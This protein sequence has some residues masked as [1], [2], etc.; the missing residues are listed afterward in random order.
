M[1]MI[2]ALRKM[3]ESEIAHAHAN[4]E[5]YLKNPAVIGEHPDL[6]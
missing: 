1:K 6:V 2:V 3:Y 4:I 5:V